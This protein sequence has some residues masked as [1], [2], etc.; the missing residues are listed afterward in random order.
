[1]TDITLM[2]DIM[3]NLTDLFR[4]SAARSDHPA[5]P[6]KPRN[7]TTGVPLPADLDGYVFKAK[8]PT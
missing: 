5:S 1:L 3:R 6:A 8:T 7:L 2:T 4:E